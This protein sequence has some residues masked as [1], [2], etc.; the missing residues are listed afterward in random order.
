LRY[1]AIV[2]SIKIQKYVFESSELQQIRGASS[3]LSRVTGIGWRRLAH[4]PLARLIYCGGGNVVALFEHRQGADA[5]CRAAVD[6][7]TSATASAGAVSHIEE[8]LPGESFP[9]PPVGGW[10]S[11]AHS[12]LAAAKL[13]GRPPSGHPTNPFAKFCDVCGVRNAES[14]HPQAADPRWLCSS[15]RL[16]SLAGKLNRSYWFRQLRWYCHGQRR[17]VRALPAPADLNALG[18]LSRPQ[19]YLAVVY[20]DVNNLGVLFKSAASSCQ[21][22]AWSEAIQR[23]TRDSVFEACRSI[24]AAHDACLPFEIFLIGGDDAV[25]ACAAERVDSL[26]SAFFAAFDEGFSSSGLEISPK[27]S[28]GV[29]LAHSRFPVRQAI[30]RAEELLKIAKTRAHEKRLMDH[31]VDFLVISNGVEL[32]VGDLRKSQF[33]DQGRALLARPFTLDEFA[34]TKELALL[35]RRIPRSKVHALYDLMFTG[36]LESTFDYCDWLRN[37]D[38]PLRDSWCALLGQRGI[39]AVPFRATD[40]WTPIVDAI[41]LSEF[42]PGQAAS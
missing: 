40:G 12:C 13:A 7:L 29:V 2:D 18:E 26:L 38:S 21:Y 5:F 31:M 27:V 8:A 16:K 32:P 33:T 3:L 36:I 42:L 15:C 39:Q 11:R 4:Q 17:P 10:V 34:Y 6:S 35:L 1:L 20:L 25:L 22:S 24:I 41:E 19:G 23:I 9:G 28:A 14:R 30:E 37:L